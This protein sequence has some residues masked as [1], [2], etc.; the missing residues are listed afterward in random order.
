LWKTF[1]SK[2]I[3]V[4]PAAG[5]ALVLLSA[6]GAAQSNDP[7]EA[8]FSDDVPVFQAAALYTQTLEDAPA[9]VTLITRQE[10]QT[11]GYRNIG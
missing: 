10:I 1:R 7:A 8:V 2:P 11:Y 4:P 3:T 9:H 5:L 6:S